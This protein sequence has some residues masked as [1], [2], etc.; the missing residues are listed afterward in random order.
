MNHRPMLNCIQTLVE[1]KATTMLV[2]TRVHDPDFLAEFG[3][4]YSRQFAD[5]PRFCTRLHFFAQNSV[6]DEEVL[7]YLDRISKA[8]YLGFLTLRPIIKSPIG[9]SILA[10]NTANGFIRC[11]DAFPVH[12][13][14]VEFA[15][16]GTPF[17]QQDNAVGACAQASI[18]MA[19]RTLRKREGDRA[20]DPAQ[21]TDAATK[22]FVHGRIRPNRNGLTQLQMIE[23][24]RAAGYS[25]HTIQLSHGANDQEPMDQ[26]A[27]DTASKIV[28]AYIE[29][30]I[31]VVLIL[32]PPSGGHAVVAIGHKWDEARAANV[33]TTITLPSGLALS[34]AHAASWVPALL[35]HNDNTGP[36]RDFEASAGAV[37]EYSFKYAAYA[38]PLLP[39][40]VFMTGEEAITIATS[41]FGEILQGF[42]I[43]NLLDDAGL[44]TLTASLAVRLL[45]V[46]K[47]KLRRWAA[48]EHMVPEL[49]DKIR[50]MEMPKRVWMLEIHQ[51]AQ[52]GAQT[53]ANTPE[54]LVG[55]VLI[56]P[57]ADI[58]VSSCLLIH[59]NLPA[60]V[61]LPHGIV[62]TWNR[63]EGAPFQALQTADQGPTRPI[64][65]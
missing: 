41:F 40:D 2:Q 60:L 14:G 50:L 53:K 57:T 18:W 44:T 17:M 12:I 21:I 61:G 43:E 30:E 48:T 10:A 64:R 51:V 24:I 33:R 47:R 23:A 3:A 20:Y 22:Y 27:I 26:L 37:A 1:A 34:C 42:K 49:R 56:D 45:L 11:L 63:E 5:V 19:L 46:E 35:I 38:I 58:P 7:V 25:P 29:S 13:A 59:L 39:V 4:Y 16:S 65:T 62:L 15:V 6:A 36:Y 8:S 31:P 32:F 28:H 9:A 52:Y 54:S 55:I